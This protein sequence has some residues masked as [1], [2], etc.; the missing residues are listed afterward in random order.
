[1]SPFL[2]IAAA[3]GAPAAA[4]PPMPAFLTGCWEQ[5]N[6]ASWNQECWMEPRGGLMLGASREGV[7]DR[8]NSWEHMT[9]EQKAD[10]AIIF[11]ASPG[12]KGRTPFIL[13]HASANEIRFTN[14]ANDYP[15]RIR[16]MLKEGKLEAEISLLDGSKPNRWSYTREGGSN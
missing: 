4:P 13:D 15:Q 11:H 10:G 16:Y 8:L 3:A 9:I 5:V 12:G 6:G 7:N 14:A 1:M 2:L